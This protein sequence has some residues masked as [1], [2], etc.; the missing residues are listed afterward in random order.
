MIGVARNMLTLAGSPDELAN[1]QRTIQTFDV[2]WLK[3][4]S[5]GVYALD[6]AAGG[7]PQRHR[8]LDPHH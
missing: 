2:N 7:L 3:G 4:M 5:I 8:H 1:Y 6:H